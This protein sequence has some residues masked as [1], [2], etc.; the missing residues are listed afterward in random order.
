MRAEYDRTNDRVVAVETD[1][2]RITPTHN[3]RVLGAT[4]EWL[5][6]E[7]HYPTGYEARFQ[8]LLG[9]VTQYALN[10]AGNVVVVSFP[11]ADFS[12]A[13]LRGALRE[14]V[15][16]AAQRALG[17]TDWAVIRKVETN[18][19]IP[20]EIVGERRAHRARAA[21]LKAQIAAL[22]D[23]DVPAF[24]FTFDTDTPGRPAPRAAAA[25]VKGGDGR[26]WVTDATAPGE[27]GEPVRPIDADEGH[28]PVSEGGP[29]TPKIETGLPWVEN[30]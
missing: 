30:D 29:V 22:A 2:G 11:E 3:P 9:N 5:P 7:V 6:A 8:N 24:D 4:T 21:E 19:P 14:G 25:S 28:G 13:A 1:D 16:I 26:E 15:D 17:R 18:E 20:G 27:H 10:D 12:P 23:K